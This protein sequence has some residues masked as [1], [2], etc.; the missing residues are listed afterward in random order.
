MLNDAYA[1][2]YFARNN[3]NHLKLV[4]CN[5]GNLKKSYSVILFNFNLIVALIIVLSHLFKVLE[6]GLN[7]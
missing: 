5:N 4:K 7:S 6:Y 2:N 1:N 3:P